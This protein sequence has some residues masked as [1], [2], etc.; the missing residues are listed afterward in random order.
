M[1]HRKEFVWKSRIGQVVALLLFVVGSV[2]LTA[3]AEVVDSFVAEVAVNDDG[4]LTIAETI[5]YDFGNQ[6]RHGIFRTIATT[7]PQPAREWYKRREIDVTVVEVQKDGINTPFEIIE[8]SGAVE[9]KIGDPNVTISGRHT[10]DIRYVLSGA[11]WYYPDRSPELYHNITGSDWEVPLE[12]VKVT[13]LDDGKFT[14]GNACFRGRD[15]DLGSCDIDSASS[16]I[17]FSTSLLFP[18]EQMTIAQPLIGSAVETQIIEVWRYSLFVIPFGLLVLVWAGV[19]A[20]RYKTHFWEDLPDIPYYEPYPEALPM[21]TGVLYDGRLDTRDITAGLL[22]L[23]EQGF[24]KIKKTEQ[25]VMFFFEVDDYEI[26]LMRDDAEVPTHFHEELLKLLFWYGN[27]GDTVTLSELKKSTSKQR[28]N[29]KI[30]RQ[31]NTAIVDDVVERGFY[32]QLFKFEYILPFVVAVGIIVGFGQT[33]IWWVFVKLFG[34]AAS[35]YLFITVG[36][37]ALALVVLVVI[38]RRRTKKGYQ[39]L[40][41]ITGFKDFLSVTDK[42]RFKFHN[43]PTKSPEQFLEYLPYAVA[44]GVEKEWAEV[45]KDITIPTPAW[46]D[47][48]SVGTFS[49][50]ALS[51][52]LGAFSSSLASSSGASGSSGGSAGGGSW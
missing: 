32:E 33:A 42:D 9:V 43:A 17:I 22:Y 10:Y 48:G 41:H 16:S 4:S 19:T 3:A 18:G 5:T 51:R 37:L 36:I 38:Y 35:L 27:V 2:P 15:G 40:H 6:E 28:Q 25:K 21:F 49:A 30:I 44:L 52:D 11:L 7:H 1:K 46:Y 47:S 29:Q 45:F 23:A 31:L 24:I 8:R 13:L 12:K 14:S 20:Y 34:S 50:T 26:T 39:A